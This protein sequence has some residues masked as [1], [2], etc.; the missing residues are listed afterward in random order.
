MRYYFEFGTALYTCVILIL[1]L[2]LR[3]GYYLY[4]RL[5]PLRWGSSFRTAAFAAV[6]ST[7]Y[8]SLDLPFLL[9]RHNVPAFWK[10]YAC[11]VIGRAIILTLVVCS[12]YE[13]MSLKPRS[14]WIYAAFIYVV[15]ETIRGIRQFEVNRASYGT[16]VLLTKVS[17]QL[18]DLVVCLSK[19]AK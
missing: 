16:L 9:I 12:F 11:S 5:I 15:Y 7:L 10:L 17:P 4:S 1:T 19:H 18:R 3:L 13:L 8:A 14:W 2:E 6:L